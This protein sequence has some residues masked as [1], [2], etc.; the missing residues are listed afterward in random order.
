MNYPSSR[1]E[2][3]VLP[4]KARQG[5]NLGVKLVP[6][7]PVTPGKKRNIGIAHSSGE[8]LAFIDDDAYPHRE[9]LA[10]AVKYLTDDDSVAVV[11]GPGITPD[12][13]DDLRKVSGYIYSSPLM[14]GLRSRFKRVKP[15]EVDDLHSCNMIVKREVFTK[16]KWNEKYWPGE[17]TLLC[18]DI[19]KM[20]CKII[21]APDVIVYHHRK[22]VFRPHLGQ[23]ANFGLHRG[24]LVKKYSENSRKPLY[25]FPMLLTLFL[26][27]GSAFSFLFPPFK[28]FYL[29]LLIIYVTAAFLAS[30]HAKKVKLI[31]LT[32]V[33]IML[34]H[35]TYG[36]YFLGGLVKGDLKR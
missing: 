18:H 20:G 24:F 2:I 33:G 22:P 35:I 28:K 4:D 19:V 36:L 14:G 29:T 17:D 5:L 10:N 3:I 8:L 21:E 13:D 12:E 27:V 9:W 6:T 30:L 26:I 25:F 1:Y 34:T 15:H 16:T 11:G 32:W 7:G 23:V 31:L